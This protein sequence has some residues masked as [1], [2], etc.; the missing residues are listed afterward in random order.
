[1]EGFF[2]TGGD[3][4]YKANGK[5]PGENILGLRVEENPPVRE[6]AEE[7][8]AVPASGRGARWELRR[9]WAQRPLG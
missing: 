7:G 6:P 8:D 4:G 5:G 1:M 2:K 3:P 9:A